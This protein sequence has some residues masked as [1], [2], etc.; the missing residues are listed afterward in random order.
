MSTKLR[1]HLQQDEY[2]K[3]WGDEVLSTS[4]KTHTSQSKTQIEI[5]ED[6]FFIL[7]ITYLHYAN[8]QTCQNWTKKSSLL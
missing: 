1:H 6:C 4:Q 7:F 8:Y 2:S 3:T 5:I